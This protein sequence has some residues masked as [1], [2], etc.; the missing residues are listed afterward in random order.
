MTILVTGGAGYIG[1]HFVR[2]L[3]KKK[4][5]FV[6]ID[7]FSTGHKSF[8]KDK[9]YYEVDLKNFELLKKILKDQEI[10]GIV[11]FAG[12]SIVAESQQKK[13]E[14]YENNVLA[15]KNIIKLA[16]EKNIKKFIFSSSAA[17]YGVPKEIPIKESHPT[18]PINNYGKNKIEIE[19]F[20]K[21]F[22]IEFPLDVV[23]LRYFNA[24]GAD[25]KGDI[26]EKRNP[27]T[28]LIPNVINAALD[29][30]VLELYGDTFNTDDGT[31][32][33]DFIHVNDL[34]KAHWSAL[35]Y[36]TSNKG[37]HIFNLGSEKGFSV[38]ET[39]KECQRL[40]KQEIKYKV[41]PARDGDPDILIAD[42][43]KSKNK[44]KW[45]IENSSLE[46]IISSA[47]NFHKNVK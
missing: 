37:F 35:D 16:I 1:S 42:S 13:Q 19:N 44:L 41:Y 10:S 32:I 47:I 14:Y 24:A 12:S 20:L 46:S 29:S 18:E 22:S 17:V 5:N 28:H 27:E 33:R 2:L 15:S 11:H 23:C 4:A 8:V 38:L 26:G 7:N 36:L 25:E 45:K 43:T 34:A 21:D 30:R 3:E 40:L 31:C 39:V 9:N 6:I